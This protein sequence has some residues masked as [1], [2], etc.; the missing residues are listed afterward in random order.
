[1]PV[2]HCD[3]CGIGRRRK[4]I[5]FFGSN[6]TDSRFTKHKTHVEPLRC[7]TQCSF[8]IFH[9]IFRQC[10]CQNVKIKTKKIKPSPRGDEGDRSLCFRSNETNLWQTQSLFFCRFCSIFVEQSVGLLKTSRVLSAS[11][12]P[13]SHHTNRILP[14]HLSL[15]KSLSCVCLSG[16]KSAKVVWSS[17]SL[18]VNVSPLWLSDDVS[19]ENLRTTPGRP[20]L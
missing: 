18:W 10:N 14:S 17:A 1:M 5:F 16:M 11:T 12:Q 7:S 19:P 2:T 9:L 13:V 3:L 4:K 6:V 8:S 15:D 20:L